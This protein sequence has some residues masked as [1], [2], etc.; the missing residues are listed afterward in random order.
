M[1]IYGGVKMEKLF[2]KLVRTTAIAPTRSTEGSAGYD[3]YACMTEQIM[4]SQGETRMIASGVSIAL[5]PGYAAF[6]YARSGL[7]IKHGIIP[8]NCVGVIDS[9]YRGEIMVGI[10]NTSDMPYTIQP[11]ERIAQMV[12]T[13]CELPELIV[14]DSL[15]ETIRGNGGFGS[16]GVK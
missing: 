2:I 15:D 9:D 14:C 3:I 6:I 16:T 7:G 13:Q 5:E 10:K 4:L 11:G 8:A 12:I 1:L